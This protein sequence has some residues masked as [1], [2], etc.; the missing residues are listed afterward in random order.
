[1]NWSQ[2]GG[3]TLNSF[4]TNSYTDGSISGVSNR[5]YKLSN[6]SCYS[7][8]IGF[9][10][11]PMAA[12]STNIIANQLD[13]SPDDTLNSVF[14]QTPLP[15]G[16]ILQKLISAGNS[17]VSYTN[18]GGV[19]L[20]D[21]NATLAPGEAAFLN[22]STTN[23]YTFIFIG[24]VR[25]GTTE[26]TLPGNENSLVSPVV[27]LSGGVHTVLGYT[28]T[29]GDSVLTWIAPS[30]EYSSYGYINSKGILKWSP[31][32]PIISVGQGFMIQVNSTNAE[33]WTNNF[34]TG[35]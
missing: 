11:I 8:I 31:S 32:E 30:N 26:I 3:V 33:V 21:G 5:F 25:E 2:A 12:E 16:T 34:S 15:S 4:G 22:N 18:S 14:A 28:P 20:P 9:I 1:M 10:Q 23:S 13:A 6:G 27:P 17:F 29:P 19:W 35:P 7:A 24:L